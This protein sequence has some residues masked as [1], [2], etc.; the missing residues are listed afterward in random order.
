MVLL[1]ST[2][3]ARSVSGLLLAA[4]CLLLP[5]GAS[6]SRK[7][8]S[9]SLSTCMEKSGFS[10]T[11]FNVTFTP[12]DGQLYF[13][14]NGDSTITGNVKAKVNVRAYG[15]KV[16]EQILDPCDTEGLDGMCPMQATPMA[17]EFTRYIDKGTVD[18]IPGIAYQIPDL[19]GIAQLEVI[20][21]QG[22]MVACVEAPLSNGL[23]VE[24]NA[25]SWVTAVIAGV[26]LLVSAFVSGLGHSSTAAHIAANALGLF[27]YFQSQ[28]IV[29]MVGVPLPPLVL[30]WTA[31]FDWA[32]GIMRLQFMQKIFH[33]YIQATGGHPSS[34]LV[35]TQEVSVQ[36]AKRSLDAINKLLRRT[37]EP[38]AVEMIPYHLSR[39]ALY[40][41][42]E[43]SHLTKRSLIPR[44]NN[45]AMVDS[46]KLVKVTGIERM[47]FISRIESTNF[48]MTGLSFFVAFICFVL[49]GVYLFKVICDLLS[50]KYPSTNFRE[51]RSKWQLVLK[52]IMYRIVLIGFPQM[53][54]LCPWEMSRNDSPAAVVLAVFFFITTLGILVWAAVK[55]LLLARHSKRI[56]P[57]LGPAYTLYS[58]PSA[59]NR[60][61]YLYA[62]YAKHR[63]YFIIPVII[64]TLTRSLIIALGQSSGK[65]QA[66]AL[67]IVE[68][69][70]LIVVFT[71]QPWLD[72]R[73]NIVNISVASLNALNSVFLLVFSGI[74]GA[75]EPAIGVMGIIFFIANAIFAL[76]FLV[77]VII[78]A[79]MAV[80]S[81]N[82]EARF[83]ALPTSSSRTKMRNEKDS[84]TS[85]SSPVRDLD[86]DPISPPNSNSPA[87]ISDVS[88]V[89]PNSN[90]GDP[91]RSSTLRSQRS[92]RPY[93]G[94][95]RPGTVRR[96]SERERDVEWAA[97]Y[98]LP[99]STAGSGAT[100]RED[101][102][103]EFQGFQNHQQQQQQYH[104]GANWNTGV[105]YE[106]R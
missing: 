37:P 88:S 78:S 21:E 18:Q 80:F 14:I 73:T 60:W 35:R 83:Q 99:P 70:Y 16:L 76:I 91:R 72:R 82:P 95:S 10:A 22:K 23:T 15:F 19:D 102:Y 58:D 7:L 40:G 20:N 104:H 43:F 27:S 66:T 34:L 52:G 54:I 29:A 101:G 92:Q 31:N 11:F 42:E 24:Q 67:L 63:Y 68:F 71:L 41:F 1:F 75:P 90:A 38:T 61:G 53:A 12:D 93:T 55:I 44:S 84:D 79:C 74:T 69:I 4:A 89:S 56:D 30:A 2:K 8:S 9:T 32:M 36:I 45:D 26:A 13:H 28:A 103:A 17:I 25:V 49:I 59:M 65:A 33:W 96:D 106:G 64:Y 97:G 5:T 3:R 81:K 57:T 87:N 85:L 62:Q 6:A 77:L 46:T 100:R 94:R 48:F 86:A 98:P 105:G 47:S 51:F 39:P 50:R